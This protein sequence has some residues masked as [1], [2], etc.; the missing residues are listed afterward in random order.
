M[1]EKWRRNG[2]EFEENLRRNG[3]KGAGSSSRFP[4]NRLFSSF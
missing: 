1:E 4:R 3:L 2:G